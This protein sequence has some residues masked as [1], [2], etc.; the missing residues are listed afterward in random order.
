M[1]ETATE[2]QFLVKNMFS[3]YINKNT[4]EIR[5]LDQDGESTFQRS[6]I[7]D[8]RLYLVDNTQP[9]IENYICFL[10]RNSYKKVSR[11]GKIAAFHLHHKCF[12]DLCQWII[13]IP[14]N[15]EEYEYIL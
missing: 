4:L 14:N 10:K 9:F 12:D 5:Y 13:N 11:V 6:L 2:K 8:R 3:L 15:Y 1:T 7:Y